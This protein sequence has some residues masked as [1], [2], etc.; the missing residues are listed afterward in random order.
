M[1][2]KNIL[3]LSKTALSFEFFPPKS[4]KAC[5]DLY[6]SIHDLFARSPSYVSVTYGAGGTTRSL[7][8][9]LVLKLHREQVSTVIPHLTCVCASRSEIDALLGEYV[10]AGIENIM[11]LRGD[12]PKDVQ[13]C[14]HDFPFASDLVR[15]IK[16]NYPQIG[17]GV[18]GFPEGHPECPNR[19]KEMDYLK[20][21]VDQGADYICTQ[22]FFDNN[23]FYD[24]RDRA[25]LADIDIPI[26]AGLMPIT[27][28]SSV[29][30]IA[31]LAKGCRFPAK[32]LK[33]LARAQTDE[34]IEKIGI[35]WATEQARDLLDHDVAGI[36]FYT[37]NKSKA[38]VEIYQTLCI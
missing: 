26:I 18:A 29:G 32:L 14:H 31:E 4:E 24:F 16:Q 33:A 28:K 37:L 19:L 23:D 25:I 2:I 7:T 22:L 5:E 13:V 38:T 30:R 10:A 34:Q 21:K 17:I 6:Y 3:N 35:H 15:H 27:L 9:D 12:M 11:V 36:H 1:H 20:A 8:K